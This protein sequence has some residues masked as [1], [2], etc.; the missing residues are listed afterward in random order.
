MT[1]AEQLAEKEYPY[2][3]FEDGTWEKNDAIIAKYQID[4]ERTAFIKG[5]NAKQNELEESLQSLVDRLDYIGTIDGF[6]VN[7]KETIRD[8]SIA[9][10]LLNKET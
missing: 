1:K 7:S 4:I 2:P 6:R 5:Y 10:E 9:N 3:D 8:L